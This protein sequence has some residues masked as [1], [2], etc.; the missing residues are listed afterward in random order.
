MEL[1]EKGKLIIYLLGGIC[2]GIMG[3]IIF[4]NHSGI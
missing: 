1:I 3:V 2:L 4:L